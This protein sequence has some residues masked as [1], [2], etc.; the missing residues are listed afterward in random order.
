MKS[1]TADQIKEKLS[2]NNK[3]LIKGLLAIYNNQTQDE[4]RGKGSYVVN[5]VGFNS[6]DS[7][8]LSSMAKKV[9]RGEKI[10][11]ND[12][13]LIRHKMLK[14]SSQLE[15]IAKKKLNKM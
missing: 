9:L 15:K 12:M 6:W 14:Y 11:P 8:Y 4:R 5:G 1:Y 2:T 7:E 3:W 13:G 10:H